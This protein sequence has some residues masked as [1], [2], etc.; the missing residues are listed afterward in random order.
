M[1]INKELEQIK[2]NLKHN[3]NNLLNKEPLNYFK[4]R[5]FLEAVLIRSQRK[6]VAHDYSMVG[7]CAWKM[8]RAYAVILDRIVQ[9]TNIGNLIGLNSYIHQA[10]N[11]VFTSIIQ[12]FLKDYD[13]TYKI[14]RN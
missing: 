2:Q 9:E 14:H 6:I 5:E 8:E 7:N 11:G 13:K 1:Q 10:V 3:L 12:E 4:F